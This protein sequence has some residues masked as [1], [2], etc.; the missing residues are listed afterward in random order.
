MNAAPPATESRQTQAEA[1]YEAVLAE[2]LRI[3]HTCVIA[4]GDCPAYQTACSLLKS[5]RSEWFRKLPPSVD[6]EIE[7]IL[8][9]EE[10][11]DDRGDGDTCVYESVVERI[12]FYFSDGEDYPI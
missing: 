12:R 3:P 7:L 10:R 6:E 5:F 4:E 1:D 2:I 8:D 9:A 11:F